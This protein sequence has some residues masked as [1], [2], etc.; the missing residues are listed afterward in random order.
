MLEQK[1]LEKSTIGTVKQFVQLLIFVSLSLTVS[2]VSVS[3]ESHMHMGN[4]AGKPTKDPGIEH[5]MKKPKMYSK[6]KLCSN[7][8]MMINMWARTR[9]S[10]KHAEGDFTTCSIRCLADKVKNSG[11]PASDVQVALYTNPEKM[12]PADKATYVIGSGARGTMTMR[13]KIAFD[14]KE[15][16]EKFAATYG[17]TVTDYTGALKAATMELPKSA[18]MIDGKRKKT[19][20]IKEV[21]A[22]T[23]CTV[24]NM[25]VAKH[26]D[27]DCQILQKDNSSIHF[28]STK[29]LVKYNANPGQF[30]K[31]PKMAKMTWAKVYP[32]GG[33]EAAIGLYYVVDSKVLG[34]MGKEAIPFRS[35]KAAEE[36]VAKQGGKIVTYQE[37]TPQMVANQ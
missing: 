23:K 27:H 10:F 34:P 37:L 29:C 15:S 13:S 18:V 31:D 4:D 5:P 26:L 7:C 14:S 20:K 24:C 22:D 12:I 33:Y 2:A 19:G 9:H 28:C 36:L 32:D 30:V 21:A 3:A 6:T 17:G 1:V 8:G 16:A 11:S 35:K 25:M